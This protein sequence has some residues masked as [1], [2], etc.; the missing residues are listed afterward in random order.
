MRRAW[1]AFPIT[2]MA[3]ILFLGSDVGSAE[4]TGAFIVPL[5]RTLFPAAS[6]SQLDAMHGIIR[7]AA[8][9]GEYMVLAGL[10]IGALALGHGRSLASAARPAWLIACGCAA[11]DEA[12]QSRL[13][14][15]TASTF[16]VGLDAAAALVAVLPV[17]LGWRRAADVVTHVALWTAVAGGTLLL[18]INGMTGV[19]SRVLWVIVPAAT[20][21][22]VLRRV[23]RSTSDPAC[24]AGRRRTG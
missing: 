12:L 15:R 5:L 9:V 17:R 6:P 10:W 1:I 4:R 24:R 11:L 21:A 2:W 19:E 18:V 23:R 20:V 3:V 13:A 22:L 8:H 16:D 7:K 14:S